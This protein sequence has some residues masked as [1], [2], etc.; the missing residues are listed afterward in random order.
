MS[1]T[2]TPLNK[3]TLPDELFSHIL[4]TQQASHESVISL[5]G[6]VTASDKRTIVLLFNCFPEAVAAVHR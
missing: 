2:P 6:T 1:I 4:T 5:E 3:L